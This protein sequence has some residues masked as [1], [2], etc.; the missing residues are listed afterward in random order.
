MIGEEKKM[1]IT[2]QESLGMHCTSGF[3]SSVDITTW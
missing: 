1:A 2:S 3:P